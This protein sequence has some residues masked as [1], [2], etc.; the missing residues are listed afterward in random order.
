[1]IVSKIRKVV[2]SG[3]RVSRAHPKKKK[4]V[5]SSGNP[6]HLL[7][8][9]FNPKT[10]KRR[11][12]VAVAKAKRKNKKHSTS[13]ARRTKSRNRKAYGSAVHRAVN[14]KRGKSKNPGTRVVV[15]S[16][17]KNHRR[18]SRNPTFMGSNVSVTRMMELVA[19]G[20]IGVAINQA[21]QPM[22]P[23]SI[24]GTAIGA[25][26]AAIVVAAL[27]WWAGSL[28][29]KD[30]GAAAGFGGLMFAGSTILNQFIPSVGGF[31]SLSGRRGAGDFVP[32]R[33]AVPQNPITDAMSGMQS[34]GGLGQGAYPM[35]Y[36]RVA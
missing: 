36:G 26:V 4:S 35:A 17:R 30:L 5:R 14:R 12:T 15:I 29:D 13:N 28:I 20:L 34:S 22:L 3:G 32:G 8:L 27:E 18:K 6:A 33:F 7:T 9:G 19:A 21:V 1:L 11:N 16:P 2:N 24:T 23:A 31:V 25:S 10:H